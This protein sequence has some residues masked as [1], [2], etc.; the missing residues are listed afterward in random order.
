[1]VW[2]VKE[3]TGSDLG[4]LFNAVLRGYRKARGI[5]EICSHAFQCAWIHCCKTHYPRNM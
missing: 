1:M 3:S 2:V 4:L 5:V